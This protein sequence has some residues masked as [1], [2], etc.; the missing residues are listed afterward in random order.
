MDNFYNYL[1]KQLLEYVEAERKKGFPLE[2]IEKVLLDAGH[3]KNIIDEV[4]L[5]L[6]KEESGKKVKPHKSEVENDLLAQL[7]NA[8]SQFMA[9][10]KSEKDIKEA[11]KEF[12]KTD[13]D[14]IVK[15][16]IEEA[17]V[18]EEK[19]MFESFAFFIYLVFLGLAVLFSA[20]ATDSS[21]ISVI[22][23]FSPAIINMF[24]SFIGLNLADN[25][26]IYVSIP[27]VISGA[28]YGVGKFT[29]FP[30]FE[31]M[32]IEGLSVVTFLLGF[33]FNILIV[34]IRFV[35]PKHMKKRIIKKPRKQPK[36]D[37]EG[38]RRGL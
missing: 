15:E 3:S 6:E 8:F 10:A 5:E 34:Y 36:K 27:F 32:D 25:V 37:I 13:T 28:F 1:K 4:F 26:P 17:G 22:L 7:K 14:E 18:I 30:L 29:G 33:I 21:I 38:L 2:E 20:G 35:K 23:G 31:G 19:T 11:K 16:V 9:Q 24:I 12:E